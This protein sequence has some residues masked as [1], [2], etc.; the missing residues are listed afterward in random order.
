[1]EEHVVLMAHV[2]IRIGGAVDV[3][4]HHVVG[5]HRE[6]PDEGEWSAC[7]FLW[8]LLGIDAA[9]IDSLDEHYC[10][11][12]TSFQFWKSFFRIATYSSM[13]PGMRR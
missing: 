6:G 2:S 13:S 1:M 5:I 8:K 12:G 10:T 9:V 4:G 7:E 11:L 3:P